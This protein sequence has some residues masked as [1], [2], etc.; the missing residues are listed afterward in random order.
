LNPDR[1]IIAKHFLRFGGACLLIVLSLAFPPIVAAQVI[2][3]SFQLMR[4]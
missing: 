3:V 4:P 1:R 2:E